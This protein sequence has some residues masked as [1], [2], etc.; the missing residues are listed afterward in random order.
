MTIDYLTRRLA[1]WTEQEQM[2]ALM[3]AADA[4]GALTDAERLSYQVDSDR[5]EQLVG[6]ISE[7]IQG[8]T[9]LIEELS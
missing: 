5:A 4:I 1:Q 2:D 8:L 9:F 7:R 3:R 6:F